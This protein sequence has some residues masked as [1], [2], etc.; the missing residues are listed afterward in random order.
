MR[1][2]E[3][4]RH[5]RVHRELV[6]VVEVGEDRHLGE[7]ADARDER[8]ALESLA[9]LDDRI[10]LLERVAYLVDVALAQMSEERLVVLVDEQH[11]L[12]DMRLRILRLRLTVGGGDHVGHEE[13]ELPR[14]RFVRPE[15][16]AQTLGFRL[17]HRVD[18]RPELGDGCGLARPHVELQDGMRL[19]PIPLRLDR[20]PLEE[21]A[22]PLEKALERGDRER[23]PK[24]PGAS[25]E[26]LLADRAVGK[27]LQNRRLIDVDEPALTDVSERIGVCCDFLHAA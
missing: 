1:V 27:K 5:P 3:E 10:E 2:A 13:A 4:R 24:T 8:E 15:W 25:D 18:L 20:Q 16:Y 19:C 22:P 14:D 11:H 9:C 23:L 7:L 26:E 12:V 17:E 6:E 21:F